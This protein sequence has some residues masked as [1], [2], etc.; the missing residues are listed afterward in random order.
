MERLTQHLATARTALATLNELLRKST[1][2]K[3]ERDAASGPSSSTGTS[4]ARATVSPRQ[5]RDAPAVREV[6]LREN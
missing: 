1:R 6:G 3:V 4:A 5:P 2:S